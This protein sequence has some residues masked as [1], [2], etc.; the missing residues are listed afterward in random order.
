MGSPDPYRAVF[1]H[2]PDA[3]VIVDDG[4]RIVD[5]N[6]PASDLFGY[7]VDELIGMQVE[8]LMPAGARSV[9]AGHRARYGAHP[10]VRPMGAHLELSA[11][12]SDGT[13]VA[14]DISLSPLPGGL[15][16]AAVRDV[17]ERRRA[18][19]E[20]RQAQ[21]RAERSAQALLMANQELRLRAAVAEHLAEGIAMVRAADRVI[22]YTNDRWDRLFGYRPGE[23]LGRP[24]SDL[25]PAGVPWPADPDDEWTGEVENVRRDGTRWWALASVS[26]FVHPEHGPVHIAVHQDVT[27]R[28]LALEAAERSEASFRSVFEAS[29]IGMALVDPSCTFTSV[30]PALCEMLGFSAEE[31]T[32]RT[33][34]DVTPGED[35][36][37]DVALLAE[38]FAGELPSFTLQKRYL[39][40]HGRPVWVELRVARLPSDDGKR[41]LLIAAD[42]TARKQT[43]ADMVH[44]A[45]HDQLTGLANRSLALERLQQALA[46]IARTDE[47]VGVLFVDLDQFK[48]VNDA[49]LHAGGDEV[50]REVARRIASVVRPYDTVAR[51]G[52]D[53]FVVV[54]DGLPPGDEQAEAQL[55][56]MAERLRAAVSLPI[57]LG[58]AG[59]VRVTVSVGLAAEDGRV[60]TTPVELLNRADVGLFAAKEGGRDQVV[61]ARAGRGTSAGPA[62]PPAA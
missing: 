31:L 1:Q 34:A 40:R 32:G 39:A 20:L 22:V 37:R 10:R 44:R 49:Y 15:Y 4:G 26:T 52:G 42:I 53:E 13:E 27:A 9:H 16:A 23:L 19:A 57:D 21:A 11:L 18:A 59:V 24:A 5:A 2:A 14:V 62:A 33:F 54:C 7:P 29:P 30:N 17:T 60:P 36:R 28:R 50:L 3:V 45:L 55:V 41:A 8:Q 48:A 61:Y 12:R 56:A 25:T 6:H 46:R 35:V 51:L 47:R 38:L 58:A 43:E